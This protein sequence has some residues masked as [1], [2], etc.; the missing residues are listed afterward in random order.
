MGTEEGSSWEGPAASK[1]PLSCDP[2][3]GDDGPDAQAGAQ[4]PVLGK[5]L[6]MKVLPVPAPPSTGFRM[7]LRGQALG[8][9]VCNMG[10]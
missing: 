1:G 9:A 6:G 8:F 2:T 7:V 10:G 5:K 3:G 4:R